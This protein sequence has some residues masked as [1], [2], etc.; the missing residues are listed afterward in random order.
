M[1]F[2]DQLSKIKDNWL[3]IVIIVVLVA[4]FAGGSS[5]V[6]NLGQAT[7]KMA[8]DSV[9]SAAYRGAVYYGDEGFA[10]DVE[11]RVITKTASISSE[12]DRGRF[13]E[14]ETQLK[15]IVSSADAFLLNENANLHGSG[16]D[17]FYQ[18]SYQI[19]VD[20]AKYASVVSQ[21]KAIGEV[22]SFSEN[23]LDITGSYT[24]T[25]IEIDTEKARLARYEE[26][27]DEATDVEDKITLN[28][29]IFDQER[30]VKY[31][32]DRLSN[33]DQRVDYSTV[34]VTLTEKRSS[35][36][37]IA[38]VRFGDLVKSLVGSLNVVLY[39]LFVVVPWLVLI[40]AVAFVVR[41][42]RKLRR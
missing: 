7:Y 13:K 12:V 3:L 32:E 23:T 17:S 20:T 40:A 25:Q 21:L 29:R 19:K 8:A 42:V 38:F 36:A 39:T 1:S 30:R 9:E 11:E 22:K 6:T 16:A 26:M 34:S 5:V 15:N 35:Y 31:L 24:N 41:I 37:Q 28:D 18:G 4:I 27:Y 2:K 33:M 10:P 14:A